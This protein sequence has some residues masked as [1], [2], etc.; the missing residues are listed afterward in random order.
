MGNMTLKIIG[1][2]VGAVLGFLLYKKAGC[3]TGT[4]PIT[5]KPAVSILYG[6]VM[7]FLIGSML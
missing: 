3:K 6:A 7:G 2:V 4:C 5:S 1:T